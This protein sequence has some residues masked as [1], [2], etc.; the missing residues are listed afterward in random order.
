[1]QASKTNSEQTFDK[2]RYMQMSDKSFWFSLDKHLPEKE[3]ENKVRSRQGYVLI[4]EGQPIGLLRFNLFWDQ[5]PFCTMLFIAPGFRGQSYVRKLLEYWEND[6]RTQGF[7][8]VLT[9]TQVDEAAQH[10][11]RKSGYRDCGGLLI[12]T[13]GYAQPMEL[14]LSKDILI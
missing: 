10:F 11:Y 12:D 5:I 6:M 14:F 2:I 3:Y 1:M 4:K 13:P 7:G 8:M 9:S